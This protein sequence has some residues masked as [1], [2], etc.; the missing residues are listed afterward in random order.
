MNK[1][2]MI[3]SL[4]QPVRDEIKMGMFSTFQGTPQELEDSDEA[5]SVV[6]LGHVEDSHVLYETEYGTPWIT[7]IT[8][9]EAE[10]IKEHITDIPLTD[11][12]VQ[13]LWEITM[14][15][16]NCIPYVFTPSQ[17]EFIKKACE[18]AE[19]VYSSVDPG[20]YCLLDTDN[21]CVIDALSRG[22]CEF[23]WDDC[24]GETYK[25]DID[26]INVRK[27]LKDFDYK[28]IPIGLSQ[29]YIKACQL[30]DLEYFIEDISKLINF[31]KDDYEVIRE[32]FS[33]LEHIFTR[34]AYSYLGDGPIQDV[35]S[36]E[37]WITDELEN[38][39]SL[40]LDELKESFEEQDWDI[41][42]Y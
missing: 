18:T 37:D 5:Y 35:G 38:S 2:D 34:T 3:I 22:F 27:V 17:R 24:N 20:F 7:N 12:D 16:D 8:D 6:G 14:E 42:S 33:A 10:Y 39:Q 13:R 29:C 23:H 15:Y 19:H 30:Y 25:L 11:D 40:S 26:S 1:L 41:L 4:A 32:L 9:E 36:V 31:S 21:L 28:F